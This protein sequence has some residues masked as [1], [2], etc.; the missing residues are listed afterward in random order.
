MPLTVLAMDILVGPILSFSSLLSALLGKLLHCRLPLAGLMC[1]RNCEMQ[2][3]A[4]S[5]T[6]K[7]SLVVARIDC[8]FSKTVNGTPSRSQYVMRSTI[9]I[10]ASDTDNGFLC[11]PW[12]FFANNKSV[13]RAAD[14]SETPSPA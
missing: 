1:V 9:D 14:K 12:P 7:I 5:S 6:Y 3:A 11:L 8:Q 4:W 10:S 13:S 2:S